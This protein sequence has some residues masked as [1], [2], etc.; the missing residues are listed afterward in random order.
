M[1]EVSDIQVI[2]YDRRRKSI[3]RRTTNKMRLMLDSNILI[4]TKEK[5][6]NTKNENTTNLIDVGM[7]I[8]N[9]M[10][11]REKRDEKELSYTKKELDYLFHLAKY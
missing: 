8:N 9:A 2:Y 10:L 4:T 3:M 7:A 11:D 6:L 1:D 5:L